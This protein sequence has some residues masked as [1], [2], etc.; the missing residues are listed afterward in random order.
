MASG[1]IGITNISLL[2]TEVIA[3]GIEK[4]QTLDNA[5]LKARGWTAFVV[6]VGERGQEGF[7]GR[8]YIEA[9][10]AGSKVLARGC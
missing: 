6:E 7:S 1:A 2:R 3:A 10:D 9:V 5:Q 8:I 4:K